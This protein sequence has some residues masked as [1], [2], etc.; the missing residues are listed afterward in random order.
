IIASP[1]RKLDPSTPVLRFSW[2]PDAHVCGLHRMRTLVSPRA[3]AAGRTRNLNWADRTRIAP[4]R[5]GV[6]GDTH[7]TW[8]RG[9]VLSKLT[10]GKADTSTELTR[11][12]RPMREAF[13]QKELKEL[14]GSLKLVT[15]AASEMGVPEGAAVQALIDAGSVTFTGGCA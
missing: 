6:T 8:R 12:A 1:Q 11:L 14:E 4:A 5:L 15:T 9:S 2:L 13:D 7:L 10:D 3:Q